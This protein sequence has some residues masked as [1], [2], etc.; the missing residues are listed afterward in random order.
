MEKREPSYTV[1]GDVNWC[2]YEGEQHAGS[3][4]TLK[5]ES[6]YD[7]AIPHLDIY[8]EKMKTNLKRTHAPYVYSGTIYNSLHVGT[9]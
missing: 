6:P 5:I 8:P 1:G 2:S 9:T 3:L 7:S 4:K